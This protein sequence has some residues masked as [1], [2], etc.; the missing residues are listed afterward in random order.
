MF[1]TLGVDKKTGEA[2][3]M[4]RRGDEETGVTG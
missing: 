3:M 2:G 1:D 4:G